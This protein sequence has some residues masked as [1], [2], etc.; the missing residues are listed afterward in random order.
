MQ[1]EHNYGGVPPTE[2]AGRRGRNEEG[3][4]TQGGGGA[5]ANGGGGYSCQ[6]CG[7]TFVRKMWR[8]R[9]YLSHTGQNCFRCELCS[10]ILPDEQSYRLHHESHKVSN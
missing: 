2:E 8:T 5:G 3:G 7:K 1:R 4:N 6:I 10:C 9:H